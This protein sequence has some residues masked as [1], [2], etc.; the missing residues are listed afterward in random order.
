MNG[1][2][3]KIVNFIADEG[4]HEVELDGEK[5]PIKVLPQKLKEEEIDHEKVM[6]EERRR[7]EEYMK[8]MMEEAR[9]TRE[10]LKKVNEQLS[11]IEQQQEDFIMSASMAG[12]SRPVDQIDLTQTRQELTN[13]LED[14][15]DKIETTKSL[16]DAEDDYGFDLKNTTVDTDQEDSFECESPGSS[17]GSKKGRRVA[18]RRLDKRVQDI[19]KTIKNS[20]KQATWTFQEGNIDT[21]HHNVTLTWSKGSGRVS[22]E[23]DK[24]EIYTTKMTEVKDPFFMH[25]W[26][27]DSGLRMQILAKVG[28]Q[29]VATLSFKDHELTVNGERFTNFPSLLY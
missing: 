26:E 24:K 5:C 20:K 8:T 17:P 22:I 10:Q 13:K 6:Q 21:V 28:S 3:G 25:K 14:L 9:E 27:S 19:G 16:V 12:R 11:Y 1:K 29:K 7:Y 18:L 2:S 15:A 23:M 4:R